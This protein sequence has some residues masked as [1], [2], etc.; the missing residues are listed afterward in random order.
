MDEYI[1]NFFTIENSSVFDGQT[2]N[3]LEYR[4]KKS[5]LQGRCFR[6]GRELRRHWFTIQTAED[7]LVICDVGAECVKRLA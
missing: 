1:G 2:V 7:D 6:C 4:S 3:A 5:T